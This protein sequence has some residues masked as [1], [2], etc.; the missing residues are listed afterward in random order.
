MIAYVSVTC[1]DTVFIT[2]SAICVSNSRLFFHGLLGRSQ[3]SGSWCCQCCGTG[4]CTGSAD[5]S[6]PT[7]TQRSQE[8]QICT[9]CNCGINARF[10]TCCCSNGTT[11]PV[12]CCK[13]HQDKNKQKC[14]VHLSNSLLILDSPAHESTANVL[15][16]RFI[17]KIMF[18]NIY[19][20]VK[21]KCQWIG[22]IRYK[23]RTVQSLL[24]LG[25]TSWHQR[26]N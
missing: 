16:W 15:N 22:Q 11:F 2:P 6:T 10:N 25:R 1:F 17:F 21:L 24:N 12:V 26:S 3:K 8:P 14:W 19:S 5:A 4:N 18:E 9:T 13:Q 23:R 7:P 20:L